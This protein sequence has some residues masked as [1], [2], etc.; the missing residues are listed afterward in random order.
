MELKIEGMHCNSCVM[1]IKDVLEEAGASDVKVMI[2]K[3]SF[4][5]L[6]VKKAKELIVAEGYKV[7]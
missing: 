1:L 6:D 3:A 4:D 5:K 7:K 2:G